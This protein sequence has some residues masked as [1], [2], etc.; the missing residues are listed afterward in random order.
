MPSRDEVESIECRS[1]QSGAAFAGDG[2]TTTIKAV[3]FDLGGVLIDIDFRRA[4]AEWGRSAR[5]LPGSL[6]ERFR[7]DAAYEAHETGELGH[8]AYFQH[9]RGVL[10]VAISDDELKRGWNAIFGDPIA[11]MAEILSTLGPIVPLYVF[12]NTNS[13]HSDYWRSKYERLLRPIRQV[14]CSCELRARK[15]APQAFWAVCSSIGV[16]PK[17]VVFL[18]DLTENVQGA[19]AA[20]LTA[21][22]VRSALEARVALSRHFPVF[23]RI[24]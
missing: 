15:P 17:D 19:S 10:R 22:Q 9:L 12:S 1:F 7:F 5:I 14:F 11:G 13:T 6:L 18:D 20:G 2:L 16:E 21:Y 23:G 4:F 8:A 3:V 24:G